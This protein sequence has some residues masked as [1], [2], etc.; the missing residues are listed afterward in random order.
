[1]SEGE[2]ENVRPQLKPGQDGIDEST[3]TYDTVD[4][5]VKNVP[6]N[7]GAVGLWGISYPGFY[8]GVGGI[9]THPNLKAI[10]PQAPVSDW[11]VG[12]DFHHNGAFFLQDAFN[13]MNWFGWPRPKPSPQMRAGASVPSVSGGPY[14]FHLQMGSLGAYNERF[15]KGQVKF[16]ND[17]LA[18]DSYNQFWQDRSLPNKM[19]NVKCAVL[20][21]GG[22]FD[23]EDL[24]G[25]LNLYRHTEEQN[26][27]IENSLVMGPWYHGMWAGPNG[28][29]FHDLDLG[30]DTAK[31]YRE[32]LELP[33]FERHLRGQSVEAV[34]EATLFE[35]GSNTWNRF[36]K[37]PPAETRTTKLFTGE[38]GK[39]TENPGASGL[40]DAYRFDPNAPTPYLEK[41]DLN[42]RPTEYM[43]ADQ[44]FA[45]AR[46]DV[47]TY[48]TGPLSEDFRMAGPIVA[49]LHVS[50][51]GSDTDFVVKVID[52]WPDDAKPNS[53][54]RRMAGY[55]QLLRWEVMR[56]KFRNSLSRPE[57]FTPDKP[58]RVRFTLNDVLHRFRK[59]HR[60]MVQI[61]SGMF[62]LVDRNPGK[63]LSIPK[64]QPTDYAPVTIRIYRDSAIE[65]GQ[66]P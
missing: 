49:D 15:F 19:R 64:A 3:D 33:F 16:W 59:G 18:N 4:F 57:P 38:R 9:N 48:Q 11:F 36:P 35:T 63:F 7:N 34:P 51:S 62:P 23:A 10:S 66:V 31:F 54:G 39:L 55:Q 65:Y 40:Y 32:E 24:W 61:Q 56:G 27:G 14:A 50:T 60:L 30:T 45:S 12:D 13:F 25:A 5:L 21:V 6:D 17:M 22:W 58:T 41:P 53:R 1:M 8:A 47:L 42:R 28:D 20:T 26:P 52:V 46:A 2:F 44:T 29:R 43:I 37:W